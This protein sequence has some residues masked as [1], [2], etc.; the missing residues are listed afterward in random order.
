MGTDFESFFRAR[1]PALLRTAYLLTGDRHLAED[2]VQ[3][4]LARTFR[5]WRRIGDSGNPEA[6]ARRVMYHLQVSRWRLRRVVETMPGDLPEQHGHVDHAHDAV[7]RLALRRALLALPV[8]QR[9]V[10]VLRYFEDH[11]DTEIA[12]ILNCRV[13]TVKSHSARALRRLRAL[14]PDLDLA[15][16][17]TR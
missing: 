16:G 7:E 10:V 12:D 5:A 3:E 4:A 14:M 6:Y 9:A 13:G 1:A 2:L 11:S 8:R 15:E 17:V